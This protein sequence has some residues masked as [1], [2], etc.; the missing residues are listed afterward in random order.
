MAYFTSS[1]VIDFGMAYWV[2]YLIYASA[3]LSLLGLWWR[4]RLRLS[5]EFRS[6]FPGWYIMDVLFTIPRSGQWSM[7][8]M[9]FDLYRDENV[10][11]H[12]PRPPSPFPSASNTALHL[13]GRGWHC[14]VLFHFLWVQHPNPTGLATT[15]TLVSFFWIKR[16]HNSSSC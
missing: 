8:M 2:T 5:A 10:Q 3:T 11:Q 14:T 9:N 13:W 1:K 7:V 6:S 16:G 12:I 4:C 15:R